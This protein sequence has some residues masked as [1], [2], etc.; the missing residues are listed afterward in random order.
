MRFCDVSIDSTMYKGDDVL[1]IKI[2][3][4]PTKTNRKVKTIIISSK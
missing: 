2:L 1:E 4:E 3:D